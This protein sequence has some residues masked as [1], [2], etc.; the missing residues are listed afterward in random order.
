M[1]VADSSGRDGN[2]IELGKPRG[3]RGSQ[4]SRDENESVL[5]KLLAKQLIGQPEYDAGMEYH[6]HLRKAASGSSVPPIDRIPGQAPHDADA[7]QCEAVIWLERQN[8]KMPRVFATVL[9]LALHP[10]SHASLAE[11]DRQ[12]G[13]PENKMHGRLML[14]EALRELSEILGFASRQRSGAKYG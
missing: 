4:A 14:I 7:M 11:I 2:P 10:W 5:E 3:E 6:K 1:A 13:Y 9:A 12:M 8:A